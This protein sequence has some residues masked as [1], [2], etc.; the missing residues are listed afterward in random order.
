[1]EFSSMTGPTCCSRGSVCSRLLCGCG[2]P[3]GS[4]LCLGRHSSGACIW[5]A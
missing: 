5:L 2:D 4:L 1:M 3:R